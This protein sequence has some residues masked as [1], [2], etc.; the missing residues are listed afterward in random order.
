MFEGIGVRVKNPEACAI[1]PIP[2]LSDAPHIDDPLMARPTFDLL[3]TR[4]LRSD[5]AQN[6]FVGQ[7]G[8]S[9]KIEFIE[10]IQNPEMFLRISGT[11]DVIKAAWNDRGRVKKPRFPER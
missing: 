1:V 8:V 10:A 7:M 5:R 4:I 9:A 6:E 3:G 11:D 2:R